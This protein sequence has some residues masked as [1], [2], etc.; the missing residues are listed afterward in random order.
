MCTTLLIT[1]FQKYRYATTPTGLSPETVRNF[2]TE[3]F[4]NAGRGEGAGGFQG[5]YILRPEV[6]ESFYILNKLTGDPVYREWGWEIFQSI[7]KYC[8]TKYGYG[9]HPNVRHKE[10][11]PNDEMESFFLAETLKYLYLLFDPDSE[12]DLDKVSYSIAF[13]WKLNYIEFH[14]S[15]A[16]I[17]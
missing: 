4:F 10:M 5:S 2:N 15:I 16:I 14:S 6:I 9:A 1:L 17:K 11:N 7:E 3:T 8:K 13:L 12:V